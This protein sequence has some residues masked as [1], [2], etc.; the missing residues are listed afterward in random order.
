M[1]FK[2]IQ[3][4]F[5][6]AFVLLDIGLCISLLMG[7]QYRNSGHQQ[8]QTQITLKEMKNDMISYQALSNQRRNGYYVSAQD[9]DQWTT[10]E[11]VAALKGQ[12]SRLNNGIV[13]STFQTAVKVHPG[14]ENQRQFDKIVHSNRILH[15]REY[16]YNA[17]L[18]TR[19]QVVYTQVIKGQP[20]LDRTGQLRLHINGDNEI[21]GYTQRYLSNFKTLRPRA[22]TISQQQAVTWLYRHNQIAN[23]SRIRHVVLGY[24]KVEKNGRQAVYVPIWYVDVKSKAGDN[25]QHLRV[26]AFSGTLFKMN[27]DN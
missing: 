1:N 19:H 13:T 4:I 23:N 24:D 17:Q 7:T 6:I 5:I 15:G 22:L 2:R 14:T 16:Q 12:T 11:R 21:T 25:V 27:G 8:S 10:N 3:W 26:N 9:N 20:V 18:S